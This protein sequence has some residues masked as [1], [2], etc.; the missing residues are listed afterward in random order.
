MLSDVE[1]AQKVQLKEIKE[2]AKI[3]NIDEEDL[4]LYGKHKA[5]INLDILK[6]LP[7]R[8]GKLVLVTAI[9]PTKFGEGKTTTT[10]G[11]GQ[12]LSRRGINTMI[13][14]REP[15]LGPVFGLK[16]GATGGGYSQ[17][18]PMA[19]INLHFTGDMHAITSAVNLI[20]ACLDNHL[21]HGNELQIDFNKIVWKRALDMN[22]RALRKVE[23][24]VGGKSN[25][26]TRSEGFNITVASEIMAILCLCKNLKDFKEKVGNC[27]IAYTKDNKP[28]S[29]K[30]L[31]IQGAIAVLMKDAIKPNLVQTTE[32][33]PALIHGG[34]FANIAHGCNSIIATD[35]AL[36]LSDVVI[37]EAGFGA[38]LG[39]EKFFDIKCRNGNFTPDMVVIVATIRALKL[40]GDSKADDLKTINLQALKNGIKNLEKHLENLKKFN[41]PYVVA[42]NK[43]AS[44]AKEEVELLYQWCNE[45]NHPVFESDVFLKG[46]EGGL[47]I[48]DYIINN[49][50]KENTFKFLYDLED[51]IEN[52]IAKIAYDIYGAN[53]VKYSSKAMEDLLLIKQIGY[54]NLPVCMA[55]TPL[56]LSDNEKLLGRPTNFKI[57]VQEIRLS[58]GAGL[59]V[60]IC[61]K[62]LTMPGLPKEPA[63]TK[64]DIDEDNYIK[65]LF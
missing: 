10:I 2:I 49:F 37:T 41:V 1:I 60:P 23:V 13:C 33:T 38:D 56:S 4:E 21:Y 8:K 18:L 50:A 64:I 59:I 12:A 54:N 17:V 36:R 52:K 32:N 24:G 55:K 16:G 34:P 15:S 42:I 19:D 30:D 14:L 26:V 6:K 61:G 28:I 27:I 5:K 65:G 43:F 45:N 47:A 3:A 57:T 51:T 62:I 39:A 44:D 9:N 58:A 29:V 31:G 35:L 11:V 63:A 40:N 25:G 7:N 53:G 22:D 46:G 48:A 20:A